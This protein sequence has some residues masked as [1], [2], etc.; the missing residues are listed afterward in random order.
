VVL[1]DAHLVRATRTCATTASRRF[2]SLLQEGA[3]EYTYVAASRR[4]PVTSWF[5]PE[6]GGD[7]QPGDLRPVRHRSRRHRVGPE[8]LP[9]R[10]LATTPLQG[11]GARLAAARL[12]VGRLGPGPSPP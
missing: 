9:L 12:T 4:R 7:V 2:T 3:W 5:R 8:R 11:G 10:S 6:G 1:V